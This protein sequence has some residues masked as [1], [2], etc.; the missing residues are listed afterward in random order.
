M[1]KVVDLTGQT[2]GRLTVLSEAGRYKK[3]MATWNCQC[4][5][6]NTTIAISNNLRKGNTKSC[7]CLNLE[8][9]KTHGMAKHPLYKVWQGMK[10]RCYSENHKHYPNYGGRGITVC[11][12]W[13]DSFENFHEDV[14]EG[15]EKGLQLDRVDNDGNYEP[16]NVRWV[17]PHQNTMNT[18]SRKGSTSKYKGVCWD[19]RE[20]KWRATITKNSRSYDLGGYKNEVDAAIAYNKAAEQMFG[21]YAYLNK[22]DGVNNV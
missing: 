10:V 4:S 21:E 5:C 2:F 17:T 19:K 16:D 12:R 7:G 9:I 18:G 13:K 3:N 8:R 20:S 6:G 14:G 22:I 1:G 11:D 15:Y